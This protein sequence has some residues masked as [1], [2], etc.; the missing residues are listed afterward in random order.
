MAD[1]GLKR[2]LLALLLAGAVIMVALPMLT[3]ANGNAD[4][5]AGQPRAEVILDLPYGTGTGSVGATT[6]G[7][8]VPSSPPYCPEMF[9][10]TRDGTLWVLDTVNSRV[11]AFK[12]GEQS[13]EISTLAINKRPSLFG[14]TRD[15]V[16]V[17]K[18]T[19]LKDKGPMFSLLRCDRSSMEWKTIKLEMPDGVQFDPL[20]IMPL[21]TAET[22]LLINGMQYMANIPGSIVN[23][24]MVLD[25]ERNVV[26]VLQG[27]GSIPAADGS[28]WRFRSIDSSLPAEL[29]F[30]LDKYNGQSNQWETVIDG[31]LPRRAELSQLREKA[32]TRPLGIDEQG[33]ALVIL[34][35]GKPLSQRFIRIAS[36]GVVTNILALEELGLDSAP[37]GKYFVPEHYQ[38]L[39]DGSVLAQYA[40]PERYRIMRIFL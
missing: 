37:L 30:V 5:A 39:P 34:Y 8:P 19:N 27:G 7:Q 40:T 17:K 12:D 23:A 24:S 20:E 38:L 35:E 25:Q 29:P 32:L 31:A 11:L 2:A 14:V 13:A 16:W 33:R 18:T 15:A 9:Q 4:Q 3:M 6:A 26:R 22:A 10:M 1:R 21:G 28:I 36:S